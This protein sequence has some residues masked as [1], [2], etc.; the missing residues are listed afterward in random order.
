MVLFL[1]LIEL[2]NLGLLAEDYNGSQQQEFQSNQAK[3][4]EMIFISGFMFYD[5]GIGR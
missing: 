1:L 2:V 4:I 5:Q 3:A